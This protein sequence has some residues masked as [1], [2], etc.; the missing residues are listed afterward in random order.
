[1]VASVIVKLTKDE[2]NAEP[3][4][5]HI[6]GAQACIVHMCAVHSHMCKHVTT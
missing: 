3:S 2:H 4:Q 5:Y 6:L 1:M